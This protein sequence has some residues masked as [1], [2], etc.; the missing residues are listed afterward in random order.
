LSAQAESFVL[1][2]QR[3]RR[4]ASGIPVL[5]GGEH[6]NVT[7][8]RANLV[9]PTVYTYTIHGKPAKE[10]GSLAFALAEHKAQWKI[11]AMSWAKLTDTSLP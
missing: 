10:T 7:G 2:E 8:S 11:S 6:I 5:Q 4:F 3:C 9:L 1:R